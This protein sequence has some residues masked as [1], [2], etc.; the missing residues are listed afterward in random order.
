M[1]YS[2]EISRLNPSCFLFLTNP[3][4]AARLRDPRLLDA[5]ARGYAKAVMAYYGQ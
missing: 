2:A 4:E 1:P 3:G 5:L